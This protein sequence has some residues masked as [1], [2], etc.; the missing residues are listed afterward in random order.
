MARRLGYRG[1]L[2]S[3]IRT[4]RDRKFKTLLSVMV[5]WAVCAAARAAPPSVTRPTE[6]VVGLTMP[7]RQS[8]LS[9]IQPGRLV[10]IAAPEGSAVKAGEVVF[11]LD[12]G[13]QEARTLMAEA[14]A[15]S[16]LDIELAEARWEQAQRSGTDSAYLGNVWAGLRFPERTG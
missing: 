16:T 10:R 3:L 5:C 9:A 4:G 13:G 2:I 12:D 6:S 1:M 14:D 11:A 7:S 15:A 8:T